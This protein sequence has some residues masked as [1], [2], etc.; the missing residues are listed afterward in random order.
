MRKEILNV[1][2][3]IA[4]MADYFQTTEFKLADIKEYIKT[5]NFNNAV[6]IIP[7]DRESFI[8]GVLATVIYN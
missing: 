4:A 2:D 1:K 6:E 8:N 7:A 3:H 5:L